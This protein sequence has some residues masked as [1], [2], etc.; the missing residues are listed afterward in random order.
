M[1]VKHLMKKL[2]QSYEKKKKNICSEDVLKSYLFL[3]SHQR[4]LLQQA[5]LLLDDIQIIKIENH[6]TIRHFWIIN[7]LNRNNYR[8]LDSYC[9]CRFFFDQ[10][11]QIGRDKALCQHLIA[12]SVGTSL[13]K[14]ESRTF[15]NEDFV[16][17]LSES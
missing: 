11:Q 3:L 16:K 6:S 4:D 10:V 7:D 2:E 15:S 14:I 17:M 1:E 8:V 9:P 13:R 5:I 12:I